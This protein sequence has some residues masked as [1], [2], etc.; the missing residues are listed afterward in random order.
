M[1]ASN[2]F[3]AIF[4]NEFAGAKYIKKVKRKKV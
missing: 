3:V 1:W 4:S 2:F